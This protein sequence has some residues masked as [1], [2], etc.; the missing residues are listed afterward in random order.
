LTHPGKPRGKGGVWGGRWRSGGG[1]A[2]DH[3]SGCPR[4]TRATPTP[5]LL[6]ISSPLPTMPIDA[7]LCTDPRSIPPPFARTALGS[8][9]LLTTSAATLFVAVLN[10]PRCWHITFIF[11]PYCLYASTSSGVPAHHRAPLAANVHRS[12]PRSRPRS[13]RRSHRKKHVGPP[14]LLAHCAPAGCT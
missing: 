2:R 14:T 6:S 10:R 7:L 1:C 8:D 12:S 9:P 5:P 4:N 3:L 11:R 13:S